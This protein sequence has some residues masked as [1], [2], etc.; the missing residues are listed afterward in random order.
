MTVPD[1]L[2]LAA[3]KEEFAQEWDL[4][5]D[6]A[7]LWEIDVPVRDAVGIG[8]KRIYSTVPYSVGV[9]WTDP[10]TGEMV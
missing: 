5:P 7:D 6:E 3:V 2:E 10:E 4:A 1:N 9:E 8:G